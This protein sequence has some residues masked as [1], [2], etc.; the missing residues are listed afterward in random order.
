MK[1]N[2]NASYELQFSSKLKWYFTLTGFKSVLISFPLKSIPIHASYHFLK[3]AHTLQG[4]KLNIFFYSSLSLYLLLMNLLAFINFLLM[5][6]IQSFFFLQWCF[7]TLIH[8]VFE[9][10]SIPL[11]FVGYKLFAIL[12]QI[13][14]WKTFLHFMHY[15]DDKLETL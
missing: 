13:K 6:Y 7:I 2:S 5:T 10:L 14:S 15:L 12:L 1:I 8:W 4:W 9:V 3:L 11:I